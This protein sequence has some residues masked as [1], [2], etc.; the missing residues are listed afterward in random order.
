MADLPSVPGVPDQVLA[1]LTVVPASLADNERKR[2]GSHRRPILGRYKQLE[3][4]H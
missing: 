3:N 4:I 2:S 1:E